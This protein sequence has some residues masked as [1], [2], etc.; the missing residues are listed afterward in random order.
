MAPRVVVIRKSVGRVVIRGA[1][2]GIPGTGA[3]G[4]PGEPGPPGTGGAYF[5]DWDQGTPAAEWDVT[6]PAM[7]GIKPT[8]TVI[9]S[10][11]N[12]I[13]TDIEYIS[14]GYLKIIATSPFGGHAYLR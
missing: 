1:N 13:E 11:G 12:E 3:P 6:Y 8:V 7:G 10:G 4:T 14:D 5:F 9:D 2:V